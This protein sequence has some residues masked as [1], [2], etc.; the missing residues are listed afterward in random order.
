[1]DSS[2]SKSDAGFTRQEAGEV[3]KDSQ[4][5]K[6][7]QSCR[8]RPALRNIKTK[9]AI[10]QTRRLGLRTGKPVHCAWQARVAPLQRPHRYLMAGAGIS[11]ARSISESQAFAG[12]LTLTA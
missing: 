2:G 9:P 8:A 11:G 4:P 1:M 3:R 12:V 10:Q 6:K 5:E 7:F